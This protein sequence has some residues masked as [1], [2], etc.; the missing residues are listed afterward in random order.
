M[1][2]DDL[3]TTFDCPAPPQRIVSLV[4]SLTELLFDLGAGGW[5]VARTNFCV[6]PREQLHQK[7]SIG[8]TKNPKL[9]RI[10]NLRPDL[11]I[12]NKEE[13]QKTDIEALRAAG[14]PVWVTD[15][16]D[17]PDNQH[18]IHRLGDALDRKDAAAALIQSI[19]TAF[20]CL[21]TYTRLLPCL[22][23][24]WQKPYMAAGKDTFIDAMMSRAGLQNVLAQSRYPVLSIEEMQNLH[25]E[26][27][28]L[29]SEPYPF[30]D[31]HVAAFQ[32]LFP[33]AH[34]RLA[35]GELFSWYGSRIRLAPD[36]FLQLR[37]SLSC[38]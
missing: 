38:P 29:S 21:P 24:I 3:G 32:G 17:L 10:L 13:N 19:K 8:G 4:P 9:D 7:P 22:Y 2:Q 18:F 37:Q 11:V 26:V 16:Q 20:D 1:W 30:K 33:H 36:Y 27:I 6:H 35:D 28:L 15:I 25:P 23:L 5:V 31:K 14:L 12:A 34:I